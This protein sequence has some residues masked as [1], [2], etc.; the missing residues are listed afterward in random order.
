MAEEEPAGLS[1][2]VMMSL[3]RAVMAHWLG[4]LEE[5]EDAPALLTRRWGGLRVVVMLGQER[6]I[7]VP[8]GP[9][10]TMEASR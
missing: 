8:P 2:R 7:V 3:P 5:E 10:P 9:T 1:V 4:G 6:A